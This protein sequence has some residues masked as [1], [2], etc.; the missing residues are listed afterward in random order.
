MGPLCFWSR[1]RSSRPRTS[2]LGRRAAPSRVYRVNTPAGLRL[3]SRTMCGSTCC[4]GSRRRW[5][6]AVAS[7][8]PSG[9]RSSVGRLTCGWPRHQAPP[10]GRPSPK[11][12]REPRAR[13]QRTGRR[14]LGR[15]QPVRLY[16]PV[17]FCERGW[18]KLDRRQLRR[19]NRWA[20]VTDGPLRPP[21]PLAP[22]RALACLR[23][24]SYRAQAVPRPC[25]PIPLA[26][27]GHLPVH[28]VSCFQ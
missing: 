3:F 19:R 14:H 20:P 16:M 17:A 21:A 8:R 1:Q 23:G 15:A 2:G 4:G 24:P 28:R 12:P 13:L 25:G 27:R 5:V 10:P 26:L 18:S 22:R 6:P 9:R 7:L 11:F